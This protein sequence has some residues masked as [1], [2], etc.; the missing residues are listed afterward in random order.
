MFQNIVLIT[1][2]CSSSRKS[3]ISNFFPLSFNQ[4][5]PKTPCTVGMIQ[6]LCPL[7]ELSVNKSWSYYYTVI[8]KAIILSLIKRVA[9]PMNIN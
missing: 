9:F 5:L 1:H 7:V 4:N 2:T 6:R 8:K 3:V